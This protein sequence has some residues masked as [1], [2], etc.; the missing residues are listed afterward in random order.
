MIRGPTNEA[1]ALLL[2]VLLLFAFVGPMKFST[3]PAGVRR[4]SS[5]LWSVICTIGILARR[6]FIRSV[7]AAVTVRTDDGF[8]ELW[9]HSE[10]VGRLVGAGKGKEGTQMGRL[11]KSAKRTVL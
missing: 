5:S 10:D 3:C 4:R 2:A 11:Y 1:R 8:G 7:S 9:R 6:T